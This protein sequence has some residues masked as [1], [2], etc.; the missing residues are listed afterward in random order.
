[1]FGFRA[2]GC[3]GLAGLVPVGTKGALSHLYVVKTLSLNDSFMFTRGRRIHLSNDGLALG[4]TFGR[5]R[6]RAGLFM[7]CGA[8]SIGSSH[9]V[10]GIPTNS[11]IGGILRRLLR[12]A[13]YSIAF[14]G[15]RVVVSEGS[16]TSS[17]AGGIAN[18]IGSRGKRPVV[19]TGI[20]RGKAAG[21]AIASLGNRCDL[22]VSPST[23]LL[24]SCVNCSAGRVEISKGGV[25]GVSL[26]RGARGLS[27]VIIVNCNASEGESVMDTVSAIGKSAVDTTSA[28]GIRSTLRKGMTNLSVRSTQCTKSSRR[29]C[30]HKTESLGTKGGPLVVISNVPKDLKDMGAC[31][32]R[33]VRILG[34]TTDSTVCNSV[35]T[36]N[37][38]LMAAGEKG[39]KIGHRI[40]F[41]SCVNLGIPRV[42]PL[43][44]KRRCMRFEHSK[45]ECT[46]K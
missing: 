24:I 13:G 44:S 3:V 32:V 35:N 15:K 20:I 4:T 40:G 10:G 9:I 46:R 29:V 28:D 19:N 11:G 22:S 36:G 30:V 33:S 7:S 43:R 8:R 23:I 17:G 34:S 5:V 45:C 18:V 21:N 41:G 38:V 31:S 42:V 2:C 39:G 16:P 37:I 25:L 12:N 27:R 1:M 14:D 26:T 6:R